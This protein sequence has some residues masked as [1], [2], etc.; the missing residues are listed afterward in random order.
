M[1][2]RSSKKPIK[3]KY[4][5]QVIEIPY[6]EIKKNQENILQSLTLW[7][8]GSRRQAWNWYNRPWFFLSR[9]HLDGKHF[10]PRE[11]VEI[12][13]ADEVIELVK[14]CIGR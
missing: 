6:S 8:N 14:L 13:E 4:S 2:S 11:M 3:S 5:R 1:S 10:T 7:Y 9:T 12:G